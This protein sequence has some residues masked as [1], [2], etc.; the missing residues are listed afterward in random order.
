MFTHL[1]KGVKCWTTSRDILWITHV[2]SP[3]P[4]SGINAAWRERK[5]GEVTVSHVVIL[6]AEQKPPLLKYLRVTEHDH[7]VTSHNAS[8]H[9]FVHTAGLLQAEGSNA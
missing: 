3:Q 2:G 7:C 5:E 1:F 6:G 4:V 8:L 9:C